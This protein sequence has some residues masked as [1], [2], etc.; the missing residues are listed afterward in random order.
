MGGVV[1]LYSIHVF[2]MIYSLETTSLRYRENETFGEAADMETVG[3][4]FV[5]CINSGFLRRHNGDPIKIKKAKGAFFYSDKDQMESF[6]AVFSITIIPL[7]FEFYNIFCF[8]ES[9]E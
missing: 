2:G 6:I 7:N 8:S 5:W 4:T 1:P 9:F 3:Y